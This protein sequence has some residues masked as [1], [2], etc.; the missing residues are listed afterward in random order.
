MKNL[1]SF[2]LLLL[3][4]TIT[5]LSSCS[6][7]DRKYSNETV[8]KDLT[9]I[10]PEID[11]VDYNLLVNNITRLRMIVLLPNL[12]NSIDNKDKNP[13][14]PNS[15][16][17]MTYKD[18]LTDA[19]NIEEQKRLEILKKE[20]YLKKMTECIDI[21]YISTIYENFDYNDYLS[22]NINIT[23]KSKKPIKAFG[24][25]VEFV[26]TF[27]DVIAIRCFKYDDKTLSPNTNIK[28]QI[29]YEYNQFRN[30]DASLR[31][32]VDKYKTIWKPNHIIFTD[33]TE[34]IM[35]E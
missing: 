18:V 5:L 20:A 17:D 32:S 28:H 23:N 8:M 27:G 11:S 10:K 26:D 15:I 2:Y 21:Q 19:K 3:I 6:P 34:Y 22:H 35:K 30:S 14:I 7:L 24:G 25:C 12:F 16:Y 13:S 33:G 4:A 31:Y 29:V 1:K 9:D